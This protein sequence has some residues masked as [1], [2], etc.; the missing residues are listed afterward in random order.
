[1][2]GLIKMV[3]HTGRGEAECCI[4]VE[5]NTPSAIILILYSQMVLLIVVARQPAAGSLCPNDFS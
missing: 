5:S 2:R 1:M 4:S 3:I